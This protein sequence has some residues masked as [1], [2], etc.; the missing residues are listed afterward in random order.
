MQKLIP[1]LLFVTTILG[2]SGKNNP[3]V[4]AIKIDLTTRRFDQ[5]FFALDTNNVNNALQGLHQKYPDFLQDYLFNILALP[6]PTDSTDA[7]ENG[8][9]S[10]VQSYKPLQ[11]SSA[12]TFRDFTPVSYTHLTL[13][14]NREV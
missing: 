6:A 14:T 8:V 1:V 4:S 11:E 10:F 13:P 3:D 5:D 9:R 2:C 7:V 12:A